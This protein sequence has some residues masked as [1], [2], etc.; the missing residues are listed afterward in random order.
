[1]YLT[2]EGVLELPYANVDYNRVDR[3]FILK[4]EQSFENES[5]K[6]KQGQIN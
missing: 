2:A 1:M 6:E 5:K 4:L 3:V